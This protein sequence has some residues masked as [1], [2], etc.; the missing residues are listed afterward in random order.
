L[1]KHEKSAHGEELQNPCSSSHSSSSDHISDSDSSCASSLT[2]ECFVDDFLPDVVEPNLVDGDLH[3]DDFYLNSQIKFVSSAKTFDVDAK[4]VTDRATFLAFSRLVSALGISNERVDVLLGFLHRRDLNFEELPKSW[5]T[6]ERKLAVVVGDAIFETDEK[7]RDGELKVP[8]DISDINALNRTV[9]I[10]KRS[11]ILTAVVKL[12]LDVNLCQKSNFFC[13]PIRLFTTAGERAYGDPWTG[14][15]WERLF[16]NYVAPGC[17]PLVL[18]IFTDGTIC[19]K[20]KSRSPLVATVVNMRRAVQRAACGKTFLAFAPQVSVHK[21]SKAKAADARYRVK[22]ELYKLVLQDIRPSESSCF[23]LMVHGRIL[24][25][26]VF[27]ENFILD[28]PEQR[29]ATG[30]KSACNRC[31]CPKEKFGYELQDLEQHERAPRTVAAAKAVM[32]ECIPLM[33]SSPRPRGAVQAVEEKLDPFNLR[34]G[35]NHT[36]DFPFASPGGVFAATGT[37]RMHL[38]QGLIQ[39]LMFVLDKIFEAESPNPLKPA[40]YVQ[41][42]HE[43][44]DSRFALVASFVTPE[45]YLPRFSNGFYSKTLR[46]AWQVTAWLSLIPFLVGDD[47]AVIKSAVKRGTFLTNA[48]LLMRIVHPMWA[49]TTFTESEIS[50]LEADISKWRVHFRANYAVYVKCTHE[51]FHKLLH[52]AE[53]IREHGV[54]GNHCTNTWEQS[55]GQVKAKD[56]MTNNR[57]VPELQ[58]LKLLRVQ[59]HFDRGHHEA[60]STAKAMFSVIF[61]FLPYLTFSAAH[62]R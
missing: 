26:Q 56:R 16:N 22:Q 14:D 23:S 33:S 42:K 51:K 15:W 2:E 25:L 20:S 5:V 36:W 18:K 29:Q 41:T 19:G 61:F 53:D 62:F 45:V 11:N 54:P 28:G 24:K 50:L 9:H 34:Y 31:H 3:C 52:V 60:D 12:L 35:H 44:L 38:V 58:I 48:V 13:S 7:Y 32:A 27:V 55:H 57:F 6:Y 47:A 4:D 30:I 59:E 43:L 37:D 1:L 17:I 10:V 40:A 8:I 46:E 39:N 49:S 21:S